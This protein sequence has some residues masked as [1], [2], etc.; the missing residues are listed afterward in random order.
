MFQRAFN[1]PQGVGQMTVT[2]SLEEARKTT[3]RRTGLESPTTSRHSSLRATPIQKS[4]LRK[5]R[6][7]LSDG[8][9]FG[10]V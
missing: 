2:N 7:Q 6:V 1:A 4:P 8:F 5:N 3:D 10:S 9:G